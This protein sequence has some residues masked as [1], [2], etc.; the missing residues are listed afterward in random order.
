MRCTPYSER[1]TAYVVKSL[2][3]IPPKKQEQLTSACDMV[4]PAALAS[5]TT[6]ES[7]LSPWRSSVCAVARRKWKAMSAAC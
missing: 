4:S 7:P 5:A 3:E 2:Y 6:T 1:T